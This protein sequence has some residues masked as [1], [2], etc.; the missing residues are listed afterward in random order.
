MN[1]NESVIRALNDLLA[2]GQAMTQGSNTQSTA[3][4]TPRPSMGGYVPD[5]SVVAAGVT[6]ALP[7]PNKPSRSVPAM[8]P[9]P[10]GAVAPAPSPAAPPPG[11]MPQRIAGLG[12]APQAISPLAFGGQLPAI[13]EGGLPQAGQENGGGFMDIIGQ[14]EVWRALMNGGMRLMAAS[15]P[16]TDPR[17][18]SFGFGLSQGLGGA[19]EG[20]DDVREEKR[21]AENDEV[22][23]RYK[24][25]GIASMTAPEGV[26]LQKFYTDDGLEAYGY[27]DEGQRRMIQVGGA[28]AASGGGSGG[29]GGGGGNRKL[30]ATEQ[31]MVLEAD[32]LVAK[33]SDTIGGL[34]TALNLNEKAFEGALA[35][36]LTWVAR[37]GLGNSEA[38]IATTQLNALVLETVLPNLKA[39]FGGQPTEGERE[40]LL[41]MQAATT[42]SKEERAALLG[43]ALEAAQRRIA[44]EQEKAAALREGRYF[45]PGYAPSASGAPSGGGS[46]SG[47][48]LQ[49]NPNTKMIE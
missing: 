35:D 11:T 21:Q 18:G 28:K 34:Q 13:P 33:A 23:R 25:A 6:Q 43:R 42:M 3:G 19:M 46:P 31:N 40:I 29:A 37:Q 30:T 44:R 48:V 1:L 27:F 17:S 14:P 4:I 41:Q 32:D 2:A 49:Y 22:N 45:E 10:G 16:S 20:M 38:G 39:I 24:E 7:P 12:G 26:R 36:G 5:P 8:A 47:S 9:M 15:A